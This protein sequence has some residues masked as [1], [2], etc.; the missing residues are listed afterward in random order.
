M[1]LRISHLAQLKVVLN[2]SNEIVVFVGLYMLLNSTVSLI[3]AVA[4]V[5]KF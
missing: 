3:N 4:G 5:F 1:K 2:K